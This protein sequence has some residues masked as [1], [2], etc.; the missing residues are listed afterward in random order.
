MCTIAREW[1]CEWVSEWVETES[2]YI[3]VDWIFW[4]F[5]EEMWVWIWKTTY[6]DW[7]DRSTERISAF[8]P[9]P[10]RSWGLYTHDLSFAPFLCGFWIL[11]GQ[12][13]ERERERVRYGQMTKDSNVTLSCVR[14]GFWTMWWSD[15]DDDDGVARLREGGHW[16]RE[17]DSREK[18][19]LLFV[20]C[21][22]V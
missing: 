22:G 20:I 16:D 2:Y 10:D 19:S 13:L 11:L 21:T 15:D 18:L 9:Y 4:E 3:Y 6:L 5:I 12:K 1:A 14:N 17:R 7:N 8:C